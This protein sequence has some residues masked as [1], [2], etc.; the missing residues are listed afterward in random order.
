METIGLSIERFL[1]GARDELRKTK[2]IGRRESCFYSYFIKVYNTII[3]LYD[4]TIYLPFI[5]SFNKWLCLLGFSYILWRV[6]AWEQVGRVLEEMVLVGDPVLLFRV[7]NTRVFFIINFQSFLYSN[8]TWCPLRIG[9]FY[10][11]NAAISFILYKEYTN[12]KRKPH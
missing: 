7:I 2:I 10:A 9:I 1:M 8:K 5:F 11:C 12:F 3:E 4:Q 6:S